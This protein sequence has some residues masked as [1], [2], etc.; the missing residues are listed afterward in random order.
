MHQ[1]LLPPLGLE[2]FQHEPQSRF[3]PFKE[4]VNSE[5]LGA[6]FF[7][8]FERFERCRESLCVI[9]AWILGLVPPEMDI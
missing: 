8:F 7:F 1:Q 4:F 3:I 2:L 9:F 5:M 6:G